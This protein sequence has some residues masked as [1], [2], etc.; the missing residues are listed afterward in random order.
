MR[1]SVQ[2]LFKAATHGDRHRLFDRTG[3]RDAFDFSAQLEPQPFDEGHA[4]FG[5]VDAGASH[6]SINYAGLDLSRS[7]FVPLCNTLQHSN[8]RE[9]NTFDENG[10][11]YQ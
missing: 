5:F 1:D 4:D 11:A 6:T 3:E 7:K 9:R 10:L 2:A 8:A